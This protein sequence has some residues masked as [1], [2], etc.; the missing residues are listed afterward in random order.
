MSCCQILLTHLYYPPSRHHHDHHWSVGHE[1]DQFL[2]SCS[3]L[4]CT[5]RCRTLQYKEN[6]ALRLK[7]AD[8]PDRFLDSEVDLDEHIKSLMQVG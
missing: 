2:R 5:M 3:V 1:L 7:Y 8:Q 6:L 4:L